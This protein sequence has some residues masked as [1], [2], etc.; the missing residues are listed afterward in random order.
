MLDAVQQGV[1]SDLPYDEAPIPALVVNMVWIPFAEQVI[2]TA[3]HGMAEIVS[4]GVE[5][6]FVEEVQVE[7]RLRANL[8]VGLC[9][10]VEC[11]AYE[12]LIPPPGDA[13]PFEEERHRP[14]ALMIIGLAARPALQDGD[15]PMPDK[16]VKF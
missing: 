5:G 14:H 1:E 6:Q 8:F 2:G 4:R 12:R 9:Q 15:R 11:L 10:D 3:V 7:V 16:V 13:G